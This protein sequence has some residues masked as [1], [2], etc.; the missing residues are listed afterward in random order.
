MVSGTAWVVLARP[1]SLL[2]HSQSS[3]RL[4]KIVKLH[5]TTPCNR[6]PDSE[7]LGW[8]RQ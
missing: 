6:L 4:P 1:Q 5:E 8:R 2:S 7:A 3:P